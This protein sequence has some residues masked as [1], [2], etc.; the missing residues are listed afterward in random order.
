[1]KRAFGA[2]DAR[3]PSSGVNLLESPSPKSATGYCL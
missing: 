1:M 3:P 2:A